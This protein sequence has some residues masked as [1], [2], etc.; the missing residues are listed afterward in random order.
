[1]SSEEFAK[2]MSRYNN[3][4]EN[5]INS[6]IIEKMS[7][8]T[9]FD[10][11][12]HYDMFKYKI[13]IENEKHYPIL[14]KMSSEDFAEFMLKFNNRLDD[15]RLHS[16]IT[17]LK[18]REYVAFKLKYNTFA[19]CKVFQIDPDDF[20]F[21]NMTDEEFTELLDIL[22]TQEKQN[23][24]I[25]KMLS[26]QHQEFCVKVN[27]HFDRLR[28][29]LAIT[30]VDQQVEQLIKPGFEYM[31]KDDFVKFMLKYDNNLV[32]S[33]L[34]SIIRKLSPREYAVFKLKYN[35]FSTCNVFH[36][37]SANYDRIFQERVCDYIFLNY[38][39]EKVSALSAPAVPEEEEMM[40]SLAEVHSDFNFTY[41]GIDN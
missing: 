6:R 31:M 38:V 37:E 27:S 29:E 20:K 24:F 3:L 12:L 18:P 13:K 14:T 16:V 32:N 33:D 41:F 8:E 19:R 15:P 30:E 21:G 39:N 10:F 28:S 40:P 17:N 2:F 4:L 7:D 22:D 1:M 5:I 11:I 25:A 26:T 9:F 35:N 36:I 23:A 34:L